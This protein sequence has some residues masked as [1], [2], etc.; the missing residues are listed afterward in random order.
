[1]GR[2]SSPT[3]SGH[4]SPI[5]SPTPCLISR[6]LYSAG[7][8]A[9][10]N[11]RTARKHWELQTQA[12]LGH[13]KGKA[14]RPCSMLCRLLS[15]PQGCNP[16]VPTT[17]ASLK[18]GMGQAIASRA[19]GK[20]RARLLARQSRSLP[21]TEPE[22]S[23]PGRTSMATGG[24][25]AQRKKLLPICAGGLATFQPGTAAPRLPSPLQEEVRLGEVEMEPPWQEAGQEG[26]PGRDIDTHHLGWFKSSLRC[27]WRCV[28]RLKGLYCL[29]GCYMLKG[30][31]WM[32]LFWQGMGLCW[33]GASRGWPDSFHSAVWMGTFAESSG[34]PQKLERGKEMQAG[35]LELEGACV[36][37]CN[38]LKS[39]AR[40]C[41]PQR[42][43]TEGVCPVETAAEKP[44][45]MGQRCPAK[46]QRSRGL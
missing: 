9:R 40:W 24:S 17:W 42:A 34:S 1:M 20:A 22:Q 19:K 29:S 32:V 26:G 11:S 46:E 28:G 39:R 31:L 41:K 16:E 5:V 10:S 13:R 21:G 18:K 7:L 25:K 36:S 37:A 12:Q 2:M 43:E 15:T 38:L 27:K 8:T 35:E 45:A 14:A 3:A 30:F 4:A 6:G 33:M 44:G 23:C